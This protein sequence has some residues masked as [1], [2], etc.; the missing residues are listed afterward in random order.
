MVHLFRRIGDESVPYPSF[1]K[2]AKVELS[3]RKACPAG[4]LS[5]IPVVVG[6]GNSARRSHEYAERRR[7]RYGHF[8]WRAVSPAGD[9]CGRTEETA[10]VALRGR[11]ACGFGPCRAPW[12]CRGPDPGS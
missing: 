1:L 11:R 8:F 6:V 7:E 5:I 3:P 10:P 12:V 9:A 4:T 2:M